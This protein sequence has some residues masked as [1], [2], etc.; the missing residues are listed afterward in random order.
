MKNQLPPLNDPSPVILPKVMEKEHS[1]FCQKPPASSSP[2]YNTRNESEVDFDPHSLGKENG[3]GCC[4][5]AMHV[6]RSTVGSG[7]LMLPYAMKNSGMFSGTALI[8]FVGVLY[9][10]I[11]HILGSTDYYLCKLLKLE[12]LSFAGVMRRGFHEVPY[13]INKLETVVPHLALLS[14][15]LP[16]T[17]PTILIVM[18]TNIQIMAS[19]FDLQLNNTIII[20]AIIIPMI[21]FTQKR[22]ILKILVPFSSITN[23]LTVIMIFIII[24]FSFIY[25]K[26]DS[27]PKI[28][29]DLYFIPRAFAMFLSAVRCTGLILPL[30]NAMKNPKR[31]LDPCGSLNVAGFSIILVYC[32]FSLISYLNYGDAVQENILSNL[33]SK[34]WVC[35]IVYLFYTLSLSISFILQF[36]CCFD[37]LWSN[38]L[39]SKMKDGLFKTICERAVRIGFNLL[40]YFFALAVPRIS[41]I[42]AISGTLVILTDL[43]ILPFLQILLQIGEKKISCCEVLKDFFIIII[44]CALFYMSASQCVRDVIRLHTE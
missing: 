5:A 22:N 26:V 41:I 12:S 6:M 40:A 30:K 34:N 3:I 17:S 38:G 31:F 32:S 44:S 1:D 16:T 33:P 36:F 27:S 29:G 37:N 13:P 43:I 39:E 4:G 18:S 20:T 23:I 2:S 35:F 28:I 15:S 21:V 7:I 10:H 9:Y 25:P 8:L 19:Y 11:I 24:S 14:V 42:S